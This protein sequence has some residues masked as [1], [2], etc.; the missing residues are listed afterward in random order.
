[1]GYFIE[2]LP[3][4]SFAKSERAAEED[5]DRDDNQNNKEQHGVASDF[6]KGRGDLKAKGRKPKKPQN[7]GRAGV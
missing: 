6:W 2:T 3:G 1:M 4:E 5:L 7:S